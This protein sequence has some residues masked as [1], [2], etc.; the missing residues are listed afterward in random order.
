MKHKKALSFLNPRFLFTILAMGQH[1]QR[2]KKQKM[3]QETE[4]GNF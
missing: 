4:E 3:K 2:F 1:Q